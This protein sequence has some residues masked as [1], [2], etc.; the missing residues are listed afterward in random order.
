MA[1]YP[2]IMSDEGLLVPVGA[3]KV[4]ATIPF[5][6]DM[7]FSTLVSDYVN[8]LGNRRQLLQNPYKRIDLTYKSIDRQK[9]EIILKFFKKQKGMAR[10]FSFYYPPVFDTYYYDQFV[11]VVPSA[12]DFWVISLPSH[13][14]DVSG[15]D[16]R[17]PE[18]RV[19]GINYVYNVDYKVA[20][21]EMEGPI[22]A[23][24]SFGTISLAGD[25]TTAT[26][27]HR[28]D[29][30]VLKS[31]STIAVG[32][33]PQF[34]TV[35]AKSAFPI[36]ITTGGTLV[37][38][39]ENFYIYAGYGIGEEDR[40]FFNQVLPAG[41]PIWWSFASRDDDKFATRLR[42]DA[43]F[44]ED[45]ITD[46]DKYGSGRRYDLNIKLTSIQPDLLL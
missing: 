18:L 11:G 5:L 42:I 31:G 9:F 14:A 27:S 13:N 21:R 26:C 36:V 35:V 17:A 38:T 19:G 23:P 4:P 46:I 45:I 28:G 16:G 41:F 39:D 10:S 34:L 25:L 40:A 32:P 30:E 22:K 20:A 33:P 3:K 2:D 37:I 12:N 44:A 8:G 7:S 29:W 15:I 1:V 43:I 24:L 6:E